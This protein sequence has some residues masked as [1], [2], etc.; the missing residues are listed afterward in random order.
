M[1]IL[2]DGWPLTH[3]P[4]SPAALHLA[5]LLATCPPEVESGVAL[6][7]AQPPES[8][9]PDLEWIQ[10]RVARLH[11]ST[12]ASPRGRL[13][14]E[15][16][17]LPRLAQQF[18][19]G[20]IHTCQLSLPWLPGA[21]V[22]ASPAEWRLEHFGQV[23]NLSAPTGV[24]ERLR[25]SLG[26]GGLSRARAVFWPSDLPQPATSLA[27]RPV[28]PLVHPLF[29]NGVLPESFSGIPEN[30]FLYH[31]PLDPAEIERLLAAWSWAA[32]PLGGDFSLLI[33]GVPAAQRP[34]IEEQA[35]QAGLADSLNLVAPL[36]PPQLAALYHAC[37]ALFQT[38]P[39]SPWGDPIRHAL[40]CGKPV[41]ASAGA[42]Q[43]ALVGPAAYLVDENDTRKLGAALLTVVVEADLADELSAAALERAALWTP[44]SYWEKVLQFV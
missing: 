6:P 38:G 23:T 26:W 10:A 31:G 35:G 19:A 27:L 2:F 30:F 4:A 14:W 5:A 16:A 3:D 1:R 42:W 12:P 7:S 33:Y 21:A 22:S 28:P 17:H 18:Q 40:A 24:I 20:W 29:C 36:T 44:E 34:M 13:S 39:V 41:V 9:E 32:A 11:L 8:G 37:S 15:Q 25:Q 43:E